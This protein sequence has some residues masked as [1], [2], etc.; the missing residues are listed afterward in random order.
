MFNEGFNEGFDEGSDQG[1]DDVVTS[2]PVRSFVRDV[3]SCVAKFLPR[4][5]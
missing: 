5:C 3:A 2:R 4:L 1:S